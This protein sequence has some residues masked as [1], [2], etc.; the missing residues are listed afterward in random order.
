MT[1]FAA[2]GQRQGASLLG[3]AKA[4]NFGQACHIVMCQDKLDW[5]KKENDPNNKD[6]VT[7][8][9]WDYDPTKFSYWGCGLCWDEKVARKQFG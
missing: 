7:P 3:K 5:I 6:Y 9:R 8:A 2:T 1:G 4:R